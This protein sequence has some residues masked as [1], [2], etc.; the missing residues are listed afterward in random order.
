MKTNTR[1]F[2]G[3]L[4]NTPMNAPNT[5][6]YLA[7]GSNLLLAEIHRS[8]PSAARKCVVKLPDFALTFPRKSINRNCGVASIEVRAGS[9]VC[10][11]VYEIP[12]SE[13]QE[14]ERRE[15]FRSNRPASANSYVR[16]PQSGE[17]W[18]LAFGAVGMPMKR[19]V[20]FEGLNAK[21]GL[22]AREGVLRKHD[23]I[24]GLAIHHE[25]KFWGAALRCHQNINAVEFLQDLCEEVAIETPET[26]CQ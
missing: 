26:I 22:L 15:G 2:E 1:A 8:C 14:L 21:D 5:F 6:H 9:E 16:V 7:Y 13:R 4:P 18:H 20:D 12:V 10:G 3:S 19:V 24:A 17:L 23:F 25:G 11:G